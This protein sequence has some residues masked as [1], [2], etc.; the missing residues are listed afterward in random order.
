MYY[1]KQINIKEA[2][3]ILKE[4]DLKIPIGVDYTVGIF[5]GNTLIGTGSIS[6]DVLKGIG[7]KQDYQ[8][9]GIMAK[10]ISNLLT[11]CSEENKKNI[12]VYTK[13][14]EKKNF[15]Y[16]GFKEIAQVKYRV[17][18]LE[19]AEYGIEE[20]KI[21][22]RKKY[23][24]NKNNA[25][26][27]MNC[28]PFTIGHLHLI[29]KAA[30]ENEHVFVIILE[31]DLSSFP[32]EIRYNLVKEN[33][34]HLGNVDVI[35]G[36]KYVI[37][38]SVFPSYFTKESEHTELYARLDLNIFLN[39]IANTLRIKKRYLGK[40]PYCKVTSIYNEAMKEILPKGG[41]DVVEVERLNIDGVAV[42]A[43]KVRQLIRENE[44]NETKKY[45]PSKTYEYLVSEEAKPVI[46]RIKQNKTRH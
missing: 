35:K 14:S 3:K 5:D 6:G 23:K 20:F 37:S 16:L 24:N 2:E 26:I 9:L 12:F 19:K 40:E 34:K 29:E 44:I 10:I 33:T 21:D 25:C 1:E 43:S 31:E 15:V 32:F 7:V 45:V 22:L 18:L 30:K 42:S 11:K 36:G 41:V 46:E 8:G 28:N 17:S 39:H 38:S 13:Y 4:L 27:V